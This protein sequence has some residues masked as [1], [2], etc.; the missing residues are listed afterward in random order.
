[1]QETR[2]QN[3]DGLAAAVPS[4]EDFSG[5]PTVANRRVRA[6]RSFGDSRFIS[7]TECCDYLGIGRTKFSEVRKTVEFP[8]PYKIAGCLRWKLSDVNTYI[9]VICGKAGAA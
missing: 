7:Q 4:D 3:P 2:I 5:R 6:D 8:K 1:M 9:D